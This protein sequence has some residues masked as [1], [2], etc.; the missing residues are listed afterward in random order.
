[1]KYLV[2]IN[3]KHH[4]TMEEIVKLRTESQEKLGD[5]YVVFVS[6]GDGVTVDVY[7]KLIYNITLAL[8]RI[9]DWDYSKLYKWMFIN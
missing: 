2:H 1:M 4:L 5:D 7:P 6:I 3:I 8:K 9:R